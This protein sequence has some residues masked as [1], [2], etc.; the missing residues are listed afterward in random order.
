MH[1]T[2]SVL[3][4]FRGFCYV[5]TTKLLQSGTTAAA[6]RRRA[7][8]WNRGAPGSAL[9]G[10][11][12]SATVFAFALLGSVGFASTSISEVTLAPTS[13]ITPQVTAAQ[14]ALSDAQGARDRECRGGVGKFCRQREDAVTEARHALDAAMS[15]VRDGADPQVAAAIKLV[16]WVT[17]RAPTPTPDDFAMLRLC[18]LALLPQIGDVLLMVGRSA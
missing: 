3:I 2:P 4:L 10:W 16:A 9:A 5:F 15:E 8:L 7:N 1:S 18:L 11:M 13:R 17:R 14:S 6:A 12:V